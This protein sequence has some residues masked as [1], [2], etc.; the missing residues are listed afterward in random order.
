VLLSKMADIMSSSKMDTVCK[1]H[2][3]GHSLNRTARKKE[4]QR[5]TAANQGILR[6]IEGALP[7]YNHWE[8]EKERKQ[9][10]EYVRLI[11][12]FEP[13][14]TVKPR[15]AP[16]LPDDGDSVLPSFD[17]GAGG[18]GGG[19]GGA[20]AAG[21]GGPGARG[22]SLD[23]GGAAAASWR[24]WG[25]PSSVLAAAGAGAVGGLSAAG[26]SWSAAARGGRPG[27]AGTG[28]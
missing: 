4:L 12:E 11:C 10:E 23:E 20:A 15:V 18:T 25:A 13:S 16:T 9:Q 22:A 6:R 1:S 5:I 19:G 17:M 26:S 27:G 14:A 8:W 3:Y 2:R 7:V 28:V 21:A 24:A